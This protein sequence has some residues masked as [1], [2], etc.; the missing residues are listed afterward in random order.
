M[1]DIPDQL[2]NLGPIRQLALLT[3]DLDRTVEQWRGATGI[4]PWTVYRNVRLEGDYRG[5]TTSVTIDVGLSY[6]GEMQIEVIAPQGRGPSPY[7]H[8]DGSVRE[9]FHH[10]AWFV[11]GLD[12]KVEH[13]VSRGFA[14]VFRAEALGNS[15]RVA[16]LELPAGPML[17]EF[18]EA[19]PPI[20]E[21]FRA[22][23]AAARDPAQRGE[24][25]MIDLAG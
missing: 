11:E 8:D 10:V 6:Q 9:G 19:T 12:A 14:R 3:P 20:L 17:F 7:H 24:L 16:Y 15:T 1:I 18:I 13:A 5:R 21:G 4:G 22:G 2:A 23:I 25:T